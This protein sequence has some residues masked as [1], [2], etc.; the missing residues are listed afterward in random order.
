MPGEGSA[1]IAIIIADDHAIVRA[2]TRSALAAQGGFVIVGEASNGLEALALVRQHQPRILLLDIA[3]PQASG[4]EIIEE[5]RRWAPDT[6]V[7]ILT[8][9]VS[10][11][12]LRH[13]L[14]AGATGHFL[15]SE[16][17]AR[18]LSLL[19][20]IAMGETRLSP[21]AAARLDGAD[22]HQPLTRREMQVLHALTR[23][24]GNLQIAERLGVSPSTVDK[25]RTSLMRKLGAHSIAELLAIALREGLLDS[26]RHL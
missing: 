18:W 17:P 4:L 16:D 12:L 7:V 23:G 8:G 15:K 14:E 20:E 21:A 19:E 10:R 1:P 25:H 13:A 2:G 22:G 26:A 6:A 9:L 24:L 11:Q 3:M 5:V